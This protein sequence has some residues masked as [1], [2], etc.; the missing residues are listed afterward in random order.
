MCYSFIR[1]WTSKQQLSLWE[2]IHV[3][4][5]CDYKK[6]YP[7]PVNP[8]EDTHGAFSKDTTENKETENRKISI[9]TSIKGE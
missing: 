2:K 9:A 5:P 1:Q 3:R 8:L 4:F 6:T 7:D